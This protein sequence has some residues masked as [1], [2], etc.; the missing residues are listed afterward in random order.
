MIP[1]RVAPS[2]TVWPNR[3][4]ASRK[5][6]SN[7]SSGKA[8]DF[9]DAGDRVI[10]SSWIVPDAA[11]PDFHIPSSLGILKLENFVPLSQLK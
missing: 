4:L 2:E 3:G 6:R 10:W 5:I 9:D 7:R 11:E 1:L 8:I